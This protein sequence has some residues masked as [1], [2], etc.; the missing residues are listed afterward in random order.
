VAFSD[1]PV[2]RTLAFSM[3]RREGV[4]VVG[5]EILLRTPWQP[6]HKSHE[7]ELSQR[8]PLAL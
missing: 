8:K 7:G 1:I 6:N 2:D 4:K 5:G 3:I